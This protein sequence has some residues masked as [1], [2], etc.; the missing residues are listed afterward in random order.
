MSFVPVFCPA[1][2]VIDF[3]SE[4][5]RNSEQDIRPTVD[6]HGQAITLAA[7]ENI[8]SAI[9]QLGKGLG[10]PTGNA[11]VRLYATTGTVGVD[12]KPT[13][14]ALASTATFDVSTLTTSFQLVEF[15]F[16]TPY[17]ASAGGIA[18]VIEYTNG[19]ASNYITFGIDTSSPSHAGNWFT[20]TPGTWTGQSTIDSIFYLLRN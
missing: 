13:G 1:D 9:F 11:I 7:A 5:N 12:A 15:V 19:D 2:P 3:Y 20:G 14:A 6:S 4:S 17:S 16:A 8:R 10:S 18:V